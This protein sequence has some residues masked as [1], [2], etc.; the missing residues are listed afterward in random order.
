MIWEYL[1]F[2]YQIGRI[3]SQPI[4]EIDDIN[5]N[6]TEDVEHSIKKR[7]SENSEITE[8]YEE[9][10]EQETPNE[11]FINEHELVNK[12]KM[13]IN[14]KVVYFC[15]QCNKQIIT[16]CG[17]IRHIR[18]HSGNRPCACEKCD[19]SF[20]VKQDLIRHMRDVHEKRKIYICDICDRAFANKYARDDHRRIHTGEKPYVCKQCSKTFRTLNLL[21]IHNRSHTNYKPHL[22]SICD[23][24]F[25]SKQ[26]MIN[27]ITTHTGIKAFSCD[28][29]EKRFSVKSEATRHRAIHNVDKPFKCI[30]CKLA[31]GQKRYLRNHIKNN[32]K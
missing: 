20:R 24:C 3:I 2:R 25:Q 22:C 26:R 7:T 30:I 16:R 14:D 6:K 17:F 23:K 21:Y 5:Y 32:H 31:F 12:A 1:C 19:K 27:H 13:I 28:L 8:I 4:V 15:E 11:Y 10:S 29:C 9:T 18:I